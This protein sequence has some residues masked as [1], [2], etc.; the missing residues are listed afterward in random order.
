MKSFYQINDSSMFRDLNPR[1]GGKHPSLRAVAD[2]LRGS[3]RLAKPLALAICL[4]AVTT[5]VLAQKLASD[6]TEK[7]IEFLMD[8]E[9]TSV[10]KKDEK[11]SHTAAAVYVITR[12]KSDDPA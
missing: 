7:S 11:L 4:L 5:P 6:L 3:W 8:I 10:S 12:E 2:C 1:R 9:I